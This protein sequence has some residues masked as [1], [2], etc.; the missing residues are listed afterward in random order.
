[1]TTQKVL[2]GLLFLIVFVS[3]SFGQKIND[4]YLKT[5]CEIIFSIE[6][7]DKIDDFKF[8]FS[9]KFLDSD[10]YV[11]RKISEMKKDERENFILQY[12]KENSTHWTD[13]SSFTHWQ[14]KNYGQWRFEITNSEP[15]IIP[16]FIVFQII[17]KD[18]GSEVIARE[19][20]FRVKSYGKPLP[21]GKIDLKTDF[22]NRID[23]G[24][25]QLTLAGVGGWYVI[26][27][28]NGKIKE[29]KLFTTSSDRICVFASES[30]YRAYLLNKLNP[31]IVGEEIFNKPVDEVLCYRY[32]FQSKKRIDSPTKK[33]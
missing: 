18:S 17:L 23:P 3:V 6:S 2:I 22:I 4:D 33:S 26:G 28:V 20:I 24:E 11:M 31:S 5:T 9:F 1:M 7:T 12:T 15:V 10:K 25:Q 14:F 29:R 16:N 32:V 13:D 19:G 21:K 27:L 30:G 8:D